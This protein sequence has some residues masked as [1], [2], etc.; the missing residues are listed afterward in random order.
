M[1]K[2]IEIFRPGC[3]VDSIYS[4]DLK[5][6]KEKGIDL[7]ILDL[8]NTLLPWKNKIASQETIQWIEKA[9]AFGLKLFILSNT[10]SPARLTKV[11]DV[12]GLPSASHAL[13][14]FKKG[15][16]KAAKSMN[17]EISKTVVIGD[18]LLTDICGG[19]S[20]GMFTILVNPMDNQEFLGTKISRL[21]ENSILAS[22]AKH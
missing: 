14:P 5:A 16:F 21:I 8:D 22:L 1:A 7:L 12:L 19:N 15:F 18:Q 10:H 11:A 2:F 20:A 4:I 3:Y 13:K 17:V 9:K 6:L